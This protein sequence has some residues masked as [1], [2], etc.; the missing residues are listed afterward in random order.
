MSIFVR[1]NSEAEAVTKT[2]AVHAVVDVKMKKRL[3]FREAIDQNIFD[4]DAGSYV[5]TATNERLYVGDAIRKGLIKVRLVTIGC[6]YSDS[7]VAVLLSFHLK[8]CPH[9]ATKLRQQIVAG[10]GNFVAENGNKVLPETATLTGAATIR[11]QFC[12]LVWTGL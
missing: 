2:Y 5:N 7:F 10:N 12:C 6:L 11:Q 9:Q 3:S 8:A 1:Q 4:P